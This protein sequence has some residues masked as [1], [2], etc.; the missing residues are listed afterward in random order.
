[1]LKESL[2]VANSTSTQPS[3]DWDPSQPLAQPEK[4]KLEATINGDSGLKRGSP[5]GI[6]KRHTTRPLPHSEPE[7]SAAMREG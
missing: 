7:A 3:V 1:M 4:P 6:G 2:L 5:E